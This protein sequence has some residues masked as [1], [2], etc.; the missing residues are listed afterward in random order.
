VPIVAGTDSVGSGDEGP[1]QLP[2]LQEELELLVRDAGLSPAD[3]LVAATRSAA[4]AVG[5]SDQ[6]GTIEVGKLANLVV[7]D[8]DPLKDIANT[9]AVREVIKRGA[10]YPGGPVTLSPP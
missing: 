1:W 7:L 2:D 6:L 3:A 10:V 4:R 8:R 9:G 5:A